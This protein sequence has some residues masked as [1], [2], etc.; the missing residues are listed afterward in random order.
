MDFNLTTEE[1]A[2]LLKY[3][4]EQGLE[5]GKNTERTYVH[6][7]INQEIELLKAKG[8][9]RWSGFLDALNLL[10]KEQEQFMSDPVRD[11]WDM[12]YPGPGKNPYPLNS[13]KT[14]ESN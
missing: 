5:D 2:Q 11:L 12:L 9:D 8:D 14:E 1:I 7:L 10:Q 13:E 6:E 3:Q 4:Y